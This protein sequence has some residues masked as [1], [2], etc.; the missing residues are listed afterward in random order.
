MIPSFYGIGDVA[1]ALWTWTEANDIDAADGTPTKPCLKIPCPTWVECRMEAEGLCV[2]HGNLSDRAWPE[3]T[4]QFLSIVM[5]AHQRRLSAAKIAKVLTDIGT[6]TTPDATMLNSDTTGDLLNV[7]ALAAA[8]FRSQYRISKR[9]SVDVLLPDWA[10]EV[11]R[12]NMAQRAGV[13]DAMSITDGQITSWLTA[14]GVRP[15]FTPD[16][17]PLYNAA[18]ATRW[19]ANVTFAL[20][21]TGSYVALDGGEIDLGVVRDSTLNATND[22]TAA[23]SEQFYQVCRRGPKGRAYTVPVLVNGVTGCC[24]AA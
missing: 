13:W 10:L 1:G 23:W 8:D 9:R 24:P 18:A 20:W 5:G 14:R 15:Q 19:P 12:E 16:W 7:I 17:Q 21:L 22:F 11:L 3:L 2:T 6:P 4:K